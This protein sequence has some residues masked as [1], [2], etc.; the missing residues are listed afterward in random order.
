VCSATEVPELET[1]CAQLAPDDVAARCQALGIPA[2]RMA[3]P[4][5]LLSDPHLVARGF[6]VS[7]D[8]PGIGPLRFDR[9]SYLATDMPLSASRPAPGLG[10]HTREICHGRAPP[11][12]DGDRGSVRSR[13]ARMTLRF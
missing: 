7:V 8:Q 5:D 10:E 3:Y 6:L 4:P 9:Q 12:R 1:W 13:R 11:V 2:A